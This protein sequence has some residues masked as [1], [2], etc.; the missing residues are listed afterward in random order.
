M[1]IQKPVIVCV[2]KINNTQ[3]NADTASHHEE[4]TQ[5]I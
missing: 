4:V 1:A 3:V 2:V 5:F